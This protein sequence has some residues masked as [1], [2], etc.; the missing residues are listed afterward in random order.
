[1]G[2]GRG[3]GDLKNTK[4]IKRGKKRPSQ[5][6]GCSD[7]ER[8]WRGNQGTEGARWWLEDGGGARKGCESEE[9]GRWGR[10]GGGGGEHREAEEAVAQGEEIGVSQEDEVAAVVVVAAEVRWGLV[11]S[12]SGCSCSGYGDEWP[13]PPYA[14]C[15]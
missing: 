13:P 9:A 2:G 11:V 10:V 8:L 5:P 14:T 1:M 7:R 3:W 4:E 15:T 12:D 6:K